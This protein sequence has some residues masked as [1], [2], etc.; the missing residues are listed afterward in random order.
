MSSM[1]SA[2][3]SIPLGGGWLRLKRRLLSASAG[4]E[5]L[6]TS[7]FLN[8]VI[9]QAAQIYSL[10]RERFSFPSKGSRRRKVTEICQGVEMHGEKCAKSETFFRRRGAKMSLARGLGEVQV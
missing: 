9:R 7:C 3:M 1:F 2:L 8:A 10:V 6:V 5:T 4:D